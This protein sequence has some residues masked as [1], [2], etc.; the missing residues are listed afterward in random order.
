MNAREGNIL[1]NVLSCLEDK[2]SLDLAS[3]PVHGLLE[4]VCL[5][6]CS[7]GEATLVRIV[8]PCIPS[9]EDATMPQQK[10][11]I[12]ESPHGVLA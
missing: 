3:M 10:G 1:E 11:S 7:D 5:E 6:P 8:D 12:M 9:H 4:S 2:R